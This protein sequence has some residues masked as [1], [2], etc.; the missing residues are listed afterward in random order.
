MRVWTHLEAGHK[1][2]ASSS[3]ASP[4]APAA[5]PLQASLEA[6]RSTEGTIAWWGQN[7]EVLKRQR[8]SRQVPKQRQAQ[9]A[10]LEMAKAPLQWA[11]GPVKA[12]ELLQR[13]TTWRLLSGLAGQPLA[14]SVDGLVVGL[15]SE[16]HGVHLKARLSFG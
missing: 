9:L 3:D 13:W 10:A 5:Q 12:Q 15:E 7:L 4:N 6:A 11:L 2:K 8:E 14:A 1:P 16:A